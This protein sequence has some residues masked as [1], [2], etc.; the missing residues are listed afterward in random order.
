MQYLKLVFSGEAPFRS[1]E[2]YDSHTR[3]LIVDPAIVCH[4]D[5]TRRYNRNRCCILCFTG[6]KRVSFVYRTLN[7]G[8]LHEY[9][10]FLRNSEDL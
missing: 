7:F 8:D 1:M 4:E 10:E 3:L 6:K 2:E 9:T 5:G